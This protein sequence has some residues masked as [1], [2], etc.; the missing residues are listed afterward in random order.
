MQDLPLHLFHIVLNLLLVGVGFFGGIL[1][2]LVGVTKQYEIFDL[3]CG[4]SNN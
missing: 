1:F 4:L 3:Y 2:D